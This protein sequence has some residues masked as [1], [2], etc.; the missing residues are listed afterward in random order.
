MALLPEDNNR[1]SVRLTTLHFRTNTSPRLYLTLWIGHRFQML[2][3]SHAYFAGL[4]LQVMS[5]VM[6]LQTIDQHLIHLYHLFPLT[7]TSTQEV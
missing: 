4:G 5:M 6:G 7:P 2:L 3:Y 1:Q